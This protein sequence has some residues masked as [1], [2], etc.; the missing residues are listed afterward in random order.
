MRNQPLVAYMRP[1]YVARIGRLMWTHLQKAHS[2]EI[3]QVPDV[4]NKWGRSLQ[5]TGRFDMW[6]P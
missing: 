4:A 1:V 3:W 5:E 2:Q 6:P